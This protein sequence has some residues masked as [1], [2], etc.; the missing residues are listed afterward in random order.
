MKRTL[1]ALVAGAV[2]LTATPATAHHQQGEWRWQECRFRSLVGSP[3]EW[4]REEMYLVL[5]CGVHYWP[6]PGGYSFAWD[7]A[8]CESGWGPRAGTS[9]LGIYQFAPSTFAGVHHRWPD[10]WRRMGVPPDI[11]NPRSNI[12]YAIRKASADGWGA[13][14]AGVCA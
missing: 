7:V 3:T 2:L 14:S 9:H 5:R 8:D 1:L 11:Y 12:L 13:W 6:V 10:L 4:S